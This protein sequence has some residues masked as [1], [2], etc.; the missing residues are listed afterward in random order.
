MSYASRNKGR[1][2]SRRSGYGKNM[3]SA[4]GNRQDNNSSGSNPRDEGYSN[5]QAIEID[6]FESGIQKIQNILKK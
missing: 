2:N 5:D 1:R 3:R 4:Y 6:S